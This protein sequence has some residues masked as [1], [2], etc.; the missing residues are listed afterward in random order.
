MSKYQEALDWLYGTS[1]LLTKGAY[2]NVLQELVDKQTPKKPYW[3]HAYYC[4]ACNMEIK[5]YD[6][7]CSNCG[8]RL[9]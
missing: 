7:Y 9:E 3:N 1:N 4:D 2:K 6:N 5:K 8:Q